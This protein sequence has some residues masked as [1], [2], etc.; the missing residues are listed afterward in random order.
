ME[1]DTR[2][3]PEMKS[4]VSP[5]K[6]HDQ[7]QIPRKALLRGALASL[8]GLE[9]EDDKDVVLKDQTS[10][11]SGSLSHFTKSSQKWVDRTK[12]AHD[13]G[14]YQSP[15]TAV[16]VEHAIPLATMNTLQSGRRRSSTQDDNSM[17]ASRQGYSQ[18]P[19][20]W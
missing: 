10:T 15:P 13:A 3:A 17:V 1:T 18:R 14:S 6:L 20:N 7:F 4:L 19:C 11:T 8:P 16:P 2:L 12:V 5:T 9:D